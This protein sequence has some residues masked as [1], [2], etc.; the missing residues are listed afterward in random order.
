[1]PSTTSYTIT[2]PEVTGPSSRDITIFTSQ[3]CNINVQV[4]DYDNA[5]IDGYNEAGNTIITLVVGVGDVTA[6]FPTGTPIF[7]FSTQGAG[8]SAK[9]KVSSSAYAAS[10]TSITLTTVLGLGTAAPL[11]GDY[12]YLPFF[13]QRFFSFTVLDAATIIVDSLYFAPESSGNA[14]INVGPACG[15]YLRR[16]FDTSLQP[17]R[18]QD[19]VNLAFSVKASDVAGTTALAGLSYLVVDGARPIRQFYGDGLANFFVLESGATSGGR[20]LD[21]FFSLRSGDSSTIGNYAFGLGR[22]WRIKDSSSYWINQAFYFIDPDHPTFATLYMESNDL[23]ENGSFLRANASSSVA[24][25]TGPTLAAFTVDGKTGNTDQFYIETVISGTTT[26]SNQIRR[27]LWEVYCEP[28]HPI[29]LYWRNSV[30]A[31]SYWVFG[32]NRTVVQEIRNGQSISKH[33]DSAVDTSIGELETLGTPSFQETITVE[34]T[35]L[36]IVQANAIREVLT[37]SEVY[38]NLGRTAS[39]DAIRVIPVTNSWSYDGRA[40]FNAR[41]NKNTAGSPLY[42][43]PKDAMNRGS[44]EISFKLPINTSFDDIKAQD[45]LSGSTVLS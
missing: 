11:S 41:S 31:L 26:R 35:N 32:Y 34:E 16:N 10:K 7:V 44:I 23:A 43:K 28:E 1:M 25:A 21:K 14:D 13:P 6:N 45:A 38:L 9:A 18:N 12:I 37:S 36:N 24:V 42:P 29:Q 3:R 33:I 40:F 8:Y 17:D 19:G 20:H 22:V 27:C 2:G 15:E 39:T 5:D 30:G 4:K